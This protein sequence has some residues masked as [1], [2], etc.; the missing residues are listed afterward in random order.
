[1]IILSISHNI[2]LT[3]EERYALAA[4]RNVSVIGTNIPVWLDQGSTSEPAREIF[5]KY[6]LN[7]QASDRLV[8]GT[9]DGYKISL[10]T[11][12]SYIRLR[13]PT[14]DEWRAMSIDEQETW[15]EKNTLPPCAESLLDLKDGGGGYLRF[16]Y[17]SN[18]SKDGQK[19][20]AY[21]FVEI[22][23]IEDLEISLT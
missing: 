17:R 6:Y 15:Y 21:H 16:R 8:S 13:R 18:F 11:R 9:T 20:P 4:G 2:F 12:G 3:H 14:D 22:K 23:K 19:M 7:N 1:M 10:P 5:C